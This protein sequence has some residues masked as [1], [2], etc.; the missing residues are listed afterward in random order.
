MNPMLRVDL[1]KLPYITEVPSDGR[2]VLKMTFWDDDRAGLVLFFVVRPGES[3]RIADG[4]AE[5]APY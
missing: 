5:V 1:K 2:S 4:E 3:E